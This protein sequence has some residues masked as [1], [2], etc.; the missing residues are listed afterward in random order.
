MYVFLKCCYQG[1]LQDG[2]CY[3]YLKPG[4]VNVP[5]PYGLALD[6]HHYI[7]PFPA[8]ATLVVQSLLKQG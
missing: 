8:L 7:V 3:H 4:W 5:A 1:T 2:T 6:L